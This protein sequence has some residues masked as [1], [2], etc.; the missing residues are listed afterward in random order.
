MW[1]LRICNVTF[2]TIQLQF[3]LKQENRETIPSKHF[4]YVVVLEQGCHQKY[5]IVGNK[6]AL[7]ILI[8][9]VQQSKFELDKLV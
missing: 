9:V 7:L 8:Y 6:M 5:S 1:K 2:H 3:S 4:A